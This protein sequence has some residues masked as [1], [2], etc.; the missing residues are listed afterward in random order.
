MG[1]NED[2]YNVEGLGKRVRKSGEDIYG[3]TEVEGDGEG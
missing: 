2:E 3:R 1:V